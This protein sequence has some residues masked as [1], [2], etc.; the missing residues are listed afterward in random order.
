MQA[1]VMVVQS[2]S[3]LENLLLRLVVLLPLL[4]VFLL[5]QLEVRAAINRVERA[6]LSAL[7]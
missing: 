3:Q 2:C 4:P 7:H 1:L 6:L 5:Q